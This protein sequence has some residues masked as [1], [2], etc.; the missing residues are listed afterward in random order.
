[1]LMEIKLDE[2]I[3]Q[4]VSDVLKQWEDERKIISTAEKDLMEEYVEAKDKFANDI[5]QIELSLRSDYKDKEFTSTPISQIPEE[6][7]KFGFPTPDDE[8]TD[9]IDKNKREFKVMYGKTNGYDIMAGNPDVEKV[10][11]SLSLG[12][13]VRV[14]SKKRKKP[15]PPKASDDDKAA[16]LFHANKVGYM[17]ERAAKIYSAMC[18]EEYAKSVIDEQLM[19]VEEYVSVT[20]IEILKRIKTNKKLLEAIAGEKRNMREVQER[21]MPVSKSVSG[22]NFS[23]IFSIV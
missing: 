2:A 9:D 8:E 3:D 23:S 15:K 13:M 4:R 12:P 22:F 10:K 19:K 6:K 1:M 14:L 21:Y 18:N 17:E 5:E 20:V 7:K 11:D 16:S